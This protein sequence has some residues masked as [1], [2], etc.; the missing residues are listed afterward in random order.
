MTNLDT[1]G[2]RAKQY[3]RG[4]KDARTR[5][6]VFGQSNELGTE[7]IALNRAYSKGWNSVRPEY[8][9]LNLVQFTSNNRSKT[10]L[11]FS[12]LKQRE[13]DILE[14]VKDD[15]NSFFRHQGYVYDLGQFARIIP[16]EDLVGQVHPPMCLH[17]WHGDFD[18]WD[19]YLADSAHGGLVARY[20]R[21]RDG[22]IDPERVVI[23]TYY[24]KG[25]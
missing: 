22:D 10:L 3:E 12:E 20:P 11:M 6:A 1:K 5:G 15:T 25:S 13:R 2:N 4:Q 14:H 16:P 18:Q 21:L 7:S 8:R 19:C 24:F 23:G 17:D 9:V